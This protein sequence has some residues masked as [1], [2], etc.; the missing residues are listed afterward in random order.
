MNNRIKSSDVQLGKSFVIGPVQ[1]GGKELTPEEKFEQE[2]RARQEELRK[3]LEQMQADAEKQAQEIIAKAGQKAEEIMQQA[4]QDAVIK[5]EEA[6]NLKN[7]SIE[8]GYAEGFQK[9]YDEGLA[10]AKQ[11]IIDRVWGIDTLASSCFSVKKE[12]INSAEQEM[13]ELSTAIAEKIIRHELKVK[14]ELMQG[15][16][17]GAI[18]QLKDREE[19]KIIVNPSLTQNIYESVEELK[20]ELKGLKSVK[21]LE[22]RTIPRDGAIVESPES[23]IDARIETQL[24]EIVKNIMEEHNERCHLDTVPEEIEVRIDERAEEE[25]ESEN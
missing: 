16:I 21:I 6:E 3:I 18:K 4:E 1:K 22:D 10:Q 14:P 23:R 25:D 13:L 20:E 11:E 2:K 7:Q 9:G 5:A 19:I 17:K 8:N 24:R 12:I 15:I